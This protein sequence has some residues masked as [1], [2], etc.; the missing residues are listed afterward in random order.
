MLLCYYTLLNPPYQCKIKG[1]KK[2]IQLNIIKIVLIERGST[3]CLL[4]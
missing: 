1:Y 4:R 2:V 3:P